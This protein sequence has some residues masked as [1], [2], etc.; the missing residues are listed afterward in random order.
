MT[1]TVIIF[2]QLISNHYTNILTLTKFPRREDI[3]GEKADHAIKYAREFMWHPDFV[4]LQLFSEPCQARVI[5]EVKDESPITWSEI[6]WAFYFPLMLKDE[7][8]IFLTNGDSYFPLAIEPGMYCV[9]AKVRHL[10]YEEME[11]NP[12]L[13]K[14]YDEF[15]I[16][17]YD[18]SRP[19]N[20]RLT[21]SKSDR[22]IKP[23]IERRPELSEVAKDMLQLRGRLQEFEGA[24]S[25]IYVLDSN[26]EPVLL[27]DSEYEF[28]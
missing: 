18:E 26:Y 16:P 20:Y 25:S 1:Q 9:S 8:Q 5:V 23:G 14:I 3:S 10:N 11:G 21:F 12:Y 27:E 22:F 19:L 6:V 4:Y 24:A 7:D 13:M 28:S 17:D 15:G 2:D